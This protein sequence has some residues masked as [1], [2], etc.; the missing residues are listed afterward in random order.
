ML[1]SFTA[2]LVRLHF[3]TRASRR[4]ALHE[5]EER[6][7]LASLRAAGLRPSERGRSDYPFGARALE[8][9]VEVEGIW[10]VGRGWPGGEAVA[11]VEGGGCCR[12]GSEAGA[13]TYVPRRSRPAR[14][15]RRRVRPER[16]GDTLHGIPHEFEDD[17][18]DVEMD[19]LRHQGQGSGDG[20]F[21]T[22][23][24]RAQWRSPR[25]AVPPSHF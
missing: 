10:V 16:R 9:G 17:F 25:P 23:V 1:L 21:N 11:R 15:L 18:G 13:R 12:S 19:G 4:H 6:A 8:M 2:G 3:T 22:T 7:Y 5:K 20:I 14:K 24:E